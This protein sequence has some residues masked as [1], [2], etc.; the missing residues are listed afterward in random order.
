MRKILFIGRFLSKLRLTAPRGITPSKTQPTSPVARLLKWYP[1]SENLQALRF[2]PKYPVWFH[3]IRQAFSNTKKGAK[4]S[5][6]VAPHKQVLHEL[7][8]RLRPHGAGVI[9]LQKE[10][11]W[12]I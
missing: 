5:G 2:Y 1:L 7:N 6:S 3:Y 4:E 10:I 11:T 12:Q 9:V 8:L